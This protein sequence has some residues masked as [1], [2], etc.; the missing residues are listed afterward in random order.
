MKRLDHIRTLRN[1]TSRLEAKT[2]EGAVTVLAQIAPEKRRLQ[3]ERGNWER[4]IQKI[5][6]RL[7]EIAGMEEQLLAVAGFERSAAEGKEPA[8]LCSSLPPGFTEV[9][10]RY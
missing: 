2:P 8:G 3:Q 1:C 6:A 5:E 10:V 7:K 4:R 9:T